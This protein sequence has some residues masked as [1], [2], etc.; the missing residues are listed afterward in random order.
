[1]SWSKNDHFDRLIF[2]K[3]EVIRSALNC[4]IV[5]RMLSCVFIYLKKKKE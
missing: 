3:L 5:G 4:S 1:M 2:L